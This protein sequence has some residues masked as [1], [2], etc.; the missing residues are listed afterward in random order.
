M[1]SRDL[2]FNVM[3]VGVSRVCLLEI[4]DPLT[5]NKLYDEAASRTHILK[6]AN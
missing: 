1:K 4:A 5:R 3:G 2:E 6:N